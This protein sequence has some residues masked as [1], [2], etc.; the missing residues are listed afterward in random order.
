MCY[1]PFPKKCM[2]SALVQPGPPI[3]KKKQAS[4]HSKGISKN[5]IPFCLSTKKM[6]KNPPKK[7]NIN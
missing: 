3:P 5:F 4:V 6:F 7:K 2:A 1:A